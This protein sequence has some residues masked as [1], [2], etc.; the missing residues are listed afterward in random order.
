MDTLVQGSFVGQH[1]C[2]LGCTPANIQRNVRTPNSLWNDE[3]VGFSLVENELPV[4]ICW[5]ILT[6][7]SEYVHGVPL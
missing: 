1:F 2:D 5:T 6:K 3:M 7:M 4:P